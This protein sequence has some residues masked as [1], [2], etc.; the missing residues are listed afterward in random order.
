LWIKHQYFPLFF[1]RDK[2]ESVTE[3][4]LILQPAGAGG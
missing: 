1:S 2:I 3:S 4:R